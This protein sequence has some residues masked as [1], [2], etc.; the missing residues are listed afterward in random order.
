[1]SMHGKQANTPRC[2]FRTDGA[3]PLDRSSP[4]LNNASMSISGIL[5]AKLPPPIPLTVRRFRK[6]KQNIPQTKP[7]RDALLAFIRAYVER[8]QPVPPLAG[9]ELRA[10]AVRIVSELGLDPTTRASFSPTN[11]GARLWPPFHLK[12]ACS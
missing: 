2:P 6:P 10:H 9:E 8:E 7:E 12:S 1:M 4:T 3:M 5:S 11:F